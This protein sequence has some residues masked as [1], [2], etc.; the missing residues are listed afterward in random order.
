MV[1]KPFNL[2][3]GTGK[4]G[5]NV[6]SLAP[7]HRCDRETPQPEPSWVSST[8]AVLTACCRLISLPL[9]RYSARLTPPPLLCVKQPTT[10]PKLN[11]KSLF[12]FTD[13]R[14]PRMLRDWAT[15]HKGYE[16]NGKDAERLNNQALGICDLRTHVQ[17]DIPFCSFTH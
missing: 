7:S 3:T 13:Y 17:S 15:P 9:S 14:L 6:K 1:S 5:V 2:R 10:G 12:K 4:W 11:R 8:I 16:W